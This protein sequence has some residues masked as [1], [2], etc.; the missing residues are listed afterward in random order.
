MLLYKQDHG[1][2]S[3]KTIVLFAPRI[4][5]GFNAAAYSLKINKNNF[6]PVITQTF[7][8]MY[9]FVYV[10]HL[11]KVYEGRDWRLVCKG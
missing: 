11:N 8:W 9:L 2:D 5:C 1:F 4:L 10:C 7:H 3:I 6:Y